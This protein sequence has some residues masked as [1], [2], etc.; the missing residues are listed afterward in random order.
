MACDSKTSFFETDDKPAAIDCGLGHACQFC[1]QEDVCA[2][3]KPHHN[4]VLVEARLAEIDQIIIVLANKGGVGKSTV[5]ANLAGGLAK[6]GFRVGVADADIHGPNQSRFFGFAGC[7]VRLTDSGLATRDFADPSIPDP[8]KVGSLAFLLESDDTPVVWR[9]AYKHDFIHH[10][11]GSFDW[12]PL[13]FLIVDMPPGTGNELITL[14]DMLEGANVSALLVTTP[15]AVAQMDSMKAARFC[16]ER[17]LPLLGAVENMAEVVCPHCAGTFQLF[18][19]AALETNLSAAKVQTLTQIP[20][21]LSLSSASDE[22]LPLVLSEPESPAAS[23]FAPVIEACA[24]L[25]REDFD[26]A[27]ARALDD[28]FAENLDAE[29]LE[30][31]LSQ[32]DPAQQ[33]DMRDDLARMLEG[34]ALRLHGKAD[35]KLPKAE[36]L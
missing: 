24:I 18:P 30:A 3:D 13:D 5:S 6:R 25:G 28:V 22:G 7:K 35:A 15:Q 21:T 1:P 10:L 16:R 19:D 9:D 29:G 23:A 20:M 31:A 2:L 26:G 27:V 11:I 36:Q 33:A 17:G 12:G 14:C 4:R 8:V 34:E 32:L